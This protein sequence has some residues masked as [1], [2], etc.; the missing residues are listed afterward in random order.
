MHCKIFLKLNPC[1]DEIKQK[2]PYYCKKVLREGWGRP[3]AVNNPEETIPSA[4]FVWKECPFYARPLQW[5]F[6]SGILADVSV[7]QPFFIQTA[8]VPITPTFPLPYPLLHRIFIQN[9]GFSQPPLHVA[10]KNAKLSKAPVAKLVP[11]CPPWKN[12]IMALKLHALP[13]HRLARSSLRGK[14]K[15]ILETFVKTPIIL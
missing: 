2:K 8:S 9:W 10:V 3:K 5:F 12:V 13:L 15:G 6:C 1:G 4:L 14:L 7:G 11:W